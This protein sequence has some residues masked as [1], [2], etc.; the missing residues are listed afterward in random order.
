MVYFFSLLLIGLVFLL[1]YLFA[2]TKEVENV[3]SNTLKS[4]NRRNDDDK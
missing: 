3:V 1:F 4:N 2:Y